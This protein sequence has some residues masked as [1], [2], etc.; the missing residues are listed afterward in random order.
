MVRNSKRTILFIFILGAV[1]VSP[2]GCKKD[3][4]SSSSITYGTVSDFEGNSYKTVAIGSQ[5]WMAENLNSI[6]LNDG[7]AIPLVK[8]NTSWSNLTTPAYSY[9]ANDSTSS[10]TRWGALYNWYAVNTKK[11]C[12]TGWHVPS[13]DDWTALN[14]YLG[15]DSLA[16][17]KLKEVGTYDWYT[18][19]IYA[20]DVYGYKAL[21]FG[22]RFY[23]GSFNNFGYSGNWWSSTEISTGLAWY[24]YLSFSNG[25]LIANHNDKNYGLSVRCIKD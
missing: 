19:N 14:T 3:T 7:T 10:H 20:T 2:S 4:S 16:G 9:Y 24:R 11:L 12:P 18:P 22:Y 8:N 25:T 21:P 6:K 17:G 13:A 15:V 5:T 23:N 1:L